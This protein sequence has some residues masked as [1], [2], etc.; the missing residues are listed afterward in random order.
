MATLVLRGRVGRSIC[1]PWCHGELCRLPLVS[2]V[3][4][5]LPAPVDD[6]ARAYAA[7][8]SWSPRE[9]RW[10]FVRLV[11]V[12]REALYVELVR[13][14]E[15]EFGPYPWRFVR[16]VERRSTRL[17]LQS[18]VDGLSS[19]SP[20]RL[21][22]DG[23]VRRT[24][25]AMLLERDVLEATG[26][27]VRSSAWVH[28]YDPV[29]CGDR[30]VSAHTIAFEYCYGPVRRGFVVMHE[31]DVRACFRPSHLGAGSH[32]DNMADMARKGRSFRRGATRVVDR[33]EE[34]LF[35][36][37]GVESGSRPGSFGEALDADL[38]SRDEILV[39]WHLATG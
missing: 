17:E 14:A 37:T 20:D 22:D 7:L 34:R 27:W 30:W 1:T 4:C 11:A 8:L 13:S 15:R 38:R 28:D 21:Y 36:L 25:R 39:A 18:F 35:G 19:P 26:C 31:C 2:G 10:L 12:V 6:P 9:R 5:G 33:D 3:V 24:F 16:I 32:A 23:Q 29:A